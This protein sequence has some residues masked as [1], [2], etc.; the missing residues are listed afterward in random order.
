MTS[1]HVQ[2]VPVR[3]ATPLAADFTL[4][5]GWAK[6]AFLSEKALYTGS[7]ASL[8]LGEQKSNSKYAHMASLGHLLKSLSGF[9][10]QQHEACGRTLHFI[11]RRTDQF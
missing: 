6:I 3:E 8:V 11:S 9:I 10:R 4:E 5:G 2:G 7:S 1:L